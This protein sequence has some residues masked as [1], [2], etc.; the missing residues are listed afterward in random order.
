MI[1][2]TAEYPELKELDRGQHRLW[3]GYC[4]SKCLLTQRD[5]ISMH[6]I[7]VLVTAHKTI[8]LCYHNDYPTIKVIMGVVRDTQYLSFLCNANS[9]IRSIG[10]QV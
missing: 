6:N 9:Y 8:G 4:I 7:L 2:P 1:N 5:I 3:A 10:C